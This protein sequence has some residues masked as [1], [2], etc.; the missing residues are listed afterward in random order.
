MIVNKSNFP[1]VYQNQGIYVPETKREM[2]GS[3]IIP[4]GIIATLVKN[5]NNTMTSHERHVIWDHQ[6]LDCLFNSLT[7]PTSKK[8]QSPHYWSFVRRIHRWPMNFLHKGPVTR[9][10]ASIWWRHHDL[11]ISCNMCHG[12]HDHTFISESYKPLSFWQ[13]IQ[14]TTFKSKHH[15]IFQMLSILTSFFRTRFL[16]A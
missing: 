9:K 12:L 1:S 13:C 10:K 2:N 6:S 5:Y 4:K 15:S 3:D 16:H 7:R 8:Y 11:S 14:L